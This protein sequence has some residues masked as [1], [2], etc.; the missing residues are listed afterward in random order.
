MNHDLK[1]DTVMLYWKFKL[2]KY[3]YICS[4]K[5]LNVIFCSFAKIFCKK[6]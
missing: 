5:Y 3:V 1:N 4:L 2:Y 6:R